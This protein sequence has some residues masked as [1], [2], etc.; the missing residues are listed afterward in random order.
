MRPIL[1]PAICFIGLLLSSTAGSQP[2]PMVDLEVALVRLPD[3]ISP[4]SEGSF[5]YRLTNHGP[6][7][8]GSL[9]S[10]TF[11]VEA[12]SDYIL[13]LP[14]GPEVDFFSSSATGCRMILLFIEPLPGDPGKIGYIN[15]YPPLE[16]GESVE[17][18]VFYRVNPNLNHNLSVAWK[19]YSFGD[20]DPDESNNTFVVVFGPAAPI[21]TLS[22]VG[23]TTLI[24]CILLAFVAIRRQ[25][26]K[27]GAR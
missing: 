17:C 22:P 7:P 4:G 26:G 23:M 3:P 9:S 24:L 8:A 2:T 1:V 19:T 18:E 15:V 10:S 27:V 21:P 11:P 25:A 16:P 5:V 20:E 13:E 6:D 12:A 14:S